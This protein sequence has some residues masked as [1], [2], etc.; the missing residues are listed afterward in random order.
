MP[1]EA[2]ESP[3]LT[4]NAFCQLIITT[5]VSDPGWIEFY[6]FF[7]PIQLNLIGLDWIECIFFILSIQ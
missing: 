1:S 6:L 7:N 4:E 5:G 3:K 2:R